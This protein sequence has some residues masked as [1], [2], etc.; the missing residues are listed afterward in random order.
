MRDLNIKKYTFV[1]FILT[2][3]VALILFSYTMYLWIGIAGA[4]RKVEDNIEITGIH[5]S[6]YVNGNA[7]VSINISVS[8]PHGP[9]VPAGPHQLSF[10]GR[11]Y[12]WSSGMPKD[13]QISADSSSLGA[14]SSF[15]DR[16]IPESLLSTSDIPRR[17]LVGEQVHRF[18][19]HI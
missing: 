10:F 1:I 16:I 18:H 5:V 15:G 9:V 12:I 6:N 4:L 13:L 14:V 17:V 8:G 2:M 19:N 11:K 3:L 7:S